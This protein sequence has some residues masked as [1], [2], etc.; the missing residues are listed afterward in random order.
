MLADG[1]SLQLA[2]AELLALYRARLKAERPTLAPLPLHYADFALWQRRLA[3]AA[4]V[5]LRVGLS[6]L[7]ASAPDSM[8]S[9]AD[10]TSDLPEA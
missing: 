3:E 5:G 4:L 10:A 7:G 6:V 8:P 2:I 9:L 1:W